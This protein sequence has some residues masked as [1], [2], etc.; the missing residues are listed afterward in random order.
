[1]G[2]VF[3]CRKNPHKHLSNGVIGEAWAIEGLVKAYEIFKEDK[4]LNKAVEVFKN[5]P[6]D[7]DK[8]VWYTLNVDGSIRGING[9]FNHQLWFTAAGFQILSVKDDSEIKETCDCFMKRVSKL[10]AVYR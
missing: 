9:T 7:F 4:Y 6:L 2:N 1:M 10:H 8:G 5:H 3:Y